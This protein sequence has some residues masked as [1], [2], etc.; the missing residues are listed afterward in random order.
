LLLEA[1]DYY[2]AI[3][4]K[5]T[6]HINHTD[7][8]HLYDLQSILDKPIRQSFILSNDDQVYHLN[9]NITAMHATAFVC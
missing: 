5:M 1:E 6:E 8:R 2:I 7:A 3:E 4:I 9:D